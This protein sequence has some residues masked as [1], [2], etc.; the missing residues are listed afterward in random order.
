MAAHLG[1]GNAALYVGGDIETL[2]VSVGGKAGDGPRIVDSGIAEIGAALGNA[3]VENRGGV[4]V[5]VFG[6]VSRPGTSERT[7]A[8]RQEQQ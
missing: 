2:A 4:G 6:F 8:E 7:A 3:G 1:I 5:G